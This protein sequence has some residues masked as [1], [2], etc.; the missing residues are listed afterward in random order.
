MTIAAGSRLPEATLR[1]PTAEG[2]KPVTTSE[3]FA[4]KKIVLVGVPGAFTPTCHKTHLPGFVKDAEAFKAKGIDGIAVIAVNDHFVM[5]EWAKASGG[6]GKITF[7]A[8]GIAEFTKAAGLDI[9]LTAIGLGIRC[10]RFSALIENGTVSQIHFED[11]P[12]KVEQTA[13]EYLVC[14]L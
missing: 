11:G 4:G 9:D 8:D 7:L 2:M 13:A 3:F 12:G 10:K 1:I 14:R 5:G 6:E